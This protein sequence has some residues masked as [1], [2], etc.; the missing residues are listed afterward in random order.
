MGLISTV[1]ELSSRAVELG[2]EPGLLGEWR[3]LYLSAMWPP[4]IKLLIVA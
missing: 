2:F 3:I 4:D 1:H